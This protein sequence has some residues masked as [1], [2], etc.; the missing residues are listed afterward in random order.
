MNKYLFVVS[1]AVVLALPAISQARNTQHFYSLQ[2]VID[3]AIE[4]GSIDNSVR[5]YLRGKRVPG[6]I[7]ASFSTKSSRQ[8][9][10]QCGS[11]CRRKNVDQRRCDWAARAA[12]RDLQKYALSN[13]ANAVV[14]LESYVDGLSSPEAGKYEC[15]AGRSRVYVELRGSAAIVK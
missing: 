6:K 9:T 13:R 1:V 8:A 11:H 10:N 3:E 15:R 14:G 2:N 4:D 7:L 5:F 12:L